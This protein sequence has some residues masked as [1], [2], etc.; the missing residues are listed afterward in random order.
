MKKNWLYLNPWNTVFGNYANVC[1]II[2]SF[3]SN[4]F[5]TLYISYVFMYLRYS[6]FY[7]INLFSVQIQS[8]SMNFVKW[9]EIYIYAQ[10]TRKRILVMTLYV[11]MT[12]WLPAAVGLRTTFWLRY[13]IFLH[14]SV[15]VMNL[16][17]NV[18]WL[19]GN[20]G[21]FGYYRM[22]YDQVTWKNIIQQLNA[23]HQ[24]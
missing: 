20:I 13:C 6:S 9:K 7:L 1:T 16:P 18:K 4:I 19:I 22:N 3:P 8:F 24:V 23:D 11:R 12:S 10:Q 14:I 5:G 15:T 17:S 2:S 21:Q